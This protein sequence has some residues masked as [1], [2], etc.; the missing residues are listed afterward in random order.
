M[1]RKVSSP[2]SAEKSCVLEVTAA[3]AAAV[4]AA[5]IGLKHTWHIEQDFGRGESC[6]RQPS[7]KWQIVLL[8]FV[9]YLFY[10]LSC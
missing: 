2:Q 8:Q 3:A 7:I 5:L 9:A 6:R 1:K 4:A 10:T